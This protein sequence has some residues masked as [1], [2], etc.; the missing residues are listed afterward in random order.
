MYV[1]Y[2]YVDDHVYI[3]KITPKIITYKPCVGIV[4]ILRCFRI[5]LFSIPIELHCYSVSC[6]QCHCDKNTNNKRCTSL[7]VWLQ[8]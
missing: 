8:C 1:H 6:Q 5:M 7:I 2:N 3:A 4:F